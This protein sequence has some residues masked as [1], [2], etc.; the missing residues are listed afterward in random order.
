MKS[1]LAALTF[2]LD[3]YGRQ[4]LVGA[5]VVPIWQGN[6][7]ETNHAHSGLRLDAM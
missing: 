2:V 3:L 4:W 7:R 6:Q 1:K 5:H